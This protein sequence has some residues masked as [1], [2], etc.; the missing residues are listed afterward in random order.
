MRSDARIAQ[1]WLRDLKTGG[2]RRYSVSGELVAAVSPQAAGWK[3]VV[4]PEAGAMRALSRETA[5]NCADD[6]LKRA[7]WLL[8]NIVGGCAIE[9][10]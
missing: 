6:A 10:E 1:P 7:G 2:A 5:K 4:F 9:K 3:W 8:V